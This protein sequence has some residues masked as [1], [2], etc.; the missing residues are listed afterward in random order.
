MRRF[1]FVY[2][3]IIYFVSWN[4]CFN[5]FIQLYQQG[6]EFKFCHNRSGRRESSTNSLFQIA[7]LCC[8]LQILDDSLWSL[9]LPSDNWPSWLI[10]LFGI[11]LH[12][13]WVLHFFSYY[14]LAYPGAFLSNR[15][16]PIDG[17]QLGHMRRLSR[18]LKNISSLRQKQAI[19]ISRTTMWLERG[20][21]LG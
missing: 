3:S 13:R 9:L 5:T 10:Q 1:D 14:Y 21:A 19:M 4:S 16:H 15:S 6:W 11:K 12:R 20:L 18:M 2:T 8:N 7:L 17:L